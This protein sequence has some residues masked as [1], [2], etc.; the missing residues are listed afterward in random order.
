MSEIQELLER[1]LG[2]YPRAAT[3]TFGGNPPIKQLFQRLEQA[4]AESG[5]VTMRSP[6]L[7]IVSS[8]GRG[9]WAGVPWVTFLDPRETETTQDG[10]YVALLFR[11]D[12]SAVA[13]CVTQGTTVA[14]SRTGNGPAQLDWTIDALLQAGKRELDAAGFVL[15]QQ[16][17]L[18]ASTQLGRRY[19]RATA[20]FKLY[21]RGSV[22][23][24]GELV[25]DLKTALD[26]V[27]RHIERDQTRA[28]AA[29]YVGRDALPNLTIG[30]EQKTWGWKTWP[31]GLEELSAGSLLLF[32]S[33][34]TGGS[35]RRELDEWLPHGLQRVIFARLSSGVFE[36]QTPLWPDDL[37][38]YRVRFEEVGAADDI[39]FSE[40]R[41]SERL[42]DAFRRSSIAQSRPVA[43]VDDDSP[44]LALASAPIRASQPNMPSTAARARR[45]RTLPQ[46]DEIADAFRV[47]VDN[48]GLHVPTG[49]GDRIHALLAALVT[50]PF[51]IL[52]GLSGSGKTQ[53]ALRLGEWFGPGRTRVVPVR[54]DWNGPEALFGYQDALQSRDRLGRAAWAVPATLEFILA[55]LREPEQPYLLL[56]DEMNLAHVER[57]F[58]D[59]LSGVE[60]REGVIPDLERAQGDEW[61]PRGSVTTL[62]PLPSN[63]FV[64]GTVNVDETTYLFSP[65]VLDR[66]VTFEIRTATDDLDHTRRKP[67]RLAA[68]DPDLPA[69]LL[70][71][72]RDD[73]WHI[74]H[75][76][77]YLDELSERLKTLHRLLADTGDE[78]GHRAFRESLRLGAALHEIGGADIDRTLDHIVLL[79][80]L[81]RIHG[82]RARVE[83]LLEKLL[84]FAEDP[85]RSFDELE[86]ASS[87]VQSA[88]LEFTA[89]KVSRMLTAVRINQF[90]SFTE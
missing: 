25:K 13:L 62:L 36:D 4:L 17:D 49:G 22:P 14:L 77:A 65:K 44:L 89:S 47:A 46:L 2:D 33:G 6:P 82:A 59:F 51:V 39:E 52:T 28:I 74:D 7:K 15:D 68:A 9:N 20:A 75:P 43:V 11:G 21:E 56:L 23:Q 87:G 70:S 18:H 50:K 27:N 26:V 24:D 12:G 80:I 90:V 16:L 45:V 40:G 83:P 72:A 5:P 79:K 85:S 48:S 1:I 58:S 8:I 31:K 88:Q 10:A 66:A 37:Y 32:G 81:P 67:R 71:V 41:I 55:A 53:L 73:D 61:R 57:Y 69:G 54:P 38:P 42:V 35:P 63:L 78:F 84:V 86:L 29:V 3:G 19:E 60:S 64:I 30:Q 76:P 34:Y